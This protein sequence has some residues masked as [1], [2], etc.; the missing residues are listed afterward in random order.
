MKKILKI[1][2]GIDKEPA[3]SEPKNTNV[4]FECLECPLCGSLRAP[5]V[6]LG[7]DREVRY[8]AYRCPPD[9][10]NHGDVYKWKIMPNGEL[11]D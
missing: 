11:V 1:I 5:R 6:V 10:L 2:T 8:V 7:K 3:M 9:H 4:D